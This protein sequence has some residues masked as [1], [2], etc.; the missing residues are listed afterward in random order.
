MATRRVT[1]WFGPHRIAD[2]QADEES[3]ERYA[4]SMKRRFAGL[5][6]TN[7]P[8]DPMASGAAPVSPASDLPSEHLLWTLTVK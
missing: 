1:V 2:Y 8:I 3:A 6:T 7:D 4:A 5:R